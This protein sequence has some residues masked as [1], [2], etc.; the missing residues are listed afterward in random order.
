ME[1]EKCDLQQKRKS[2]FIPGAQRTRS[3]CTVCESVG[4]K[5]YE[6]GLQDGERPES[7]NGEPEGSNFHNLV[8]CASSE[9]DKTKTRAFKDSSEDGC[10]GWQ[11]NGTQN[12][13]V[14]SGEWV[15]RGKGREIYS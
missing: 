4:G 3:G 14:F 12:T 10:H 5:V 9:Q 7:H 2:A 8:V 15:G 1:K 13:A 6:R 11:G